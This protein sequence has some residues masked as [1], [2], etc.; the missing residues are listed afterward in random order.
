M[1]NSEPASTTRRSHSRRRRGTLVLGSL[2][3]L[4]MAVTFSAPASAAPGGA[5]GTSQTVAPVMSC[6][7][8]ATTDLAGRTGVPVSISSATESTATPGGWSACDVK[9]TIAP[10]EQFEAFLPLTTWRQL[11]LQTGCGGF[12]GNVSISAPQ[13]GG[14][15]PLTSGAFAMASDNEGHTA[16]G[17]FDGTFG[18][19]PQLRADYGHLS[20][21]KL[22]DLMK[23]LQKL[24]YGTAPAYSFYDGCSQGGH[25]GLMEAQQWPRD[26]N[27]IVAGAPAAI[28]QP[29]NVWYQGWNA[30]SNTGPDGQPILTVD[31]LAPL[32]AAVVTACGDANGLV[33]NPTACTFDPGSIQCRPG[34]DTSSC[35]T[36]AQV[37]TVRKLYGGPRDDHGDL[38]YPGWQVKGS[39]ANWAPWL[40]PVAPGAPA[41]TTI[42]WNVALNTI[43]YLAYT[44]VNPTLGLADIPFTRAGFR[45]IMS[46]TADTFDATNPDLTAFRNAGGKLIMWHGWADPAITPIGTIAYYQAVQ[47][48]MGGP[49][50]TARFARLF[51]LPGVGHCRGGQGPDSFDALSAIVDWV[52][53]GKAPDSFVVTRSATST[54]TVQSLP[55]YPYPLVATYDGHGDPDVAG[56]YRPAPPKVPFDAHVDWLGS[57]SA[58]P[59][60]H[61]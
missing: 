26:F 50:A 4:A 21:H 20:E 39:E 45:Q 48:R 27:G 59:S 16:S 11:Y 33:M 61:R 6:A 37:E 15:V 60:H 57:F 5:A 53:H 17:A 7:Q 18:A 51:M 54:S 42:D 24:F 13:A 19:D 10:Q 36:P 29:L 25:E 38:L 41:S 2:L 14:C 43:R 35:L 9:G 22:A 34:A 12:C 3:A 58:Q 1:R 28:H 49:A 46:Q 55:V 47:D 52:E 40:V 30:L 32:H 8:L 56:S 44:T 31:K 23:K